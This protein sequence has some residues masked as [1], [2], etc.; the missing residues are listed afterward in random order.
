MTKLEILKNT[1]G[2]DSFRPGQETLIDC[3]LNGQDVLSV[4]PTGAGKSIC[5]QIPAL[6][7]PGLTLV[8]SPL[9]SLMKDQVMALRENGVPAAF[10]NSSM[11]P[12][13]IRE[14]IERA[15]HGGLK[16]LYLAPERLESGD[17]AAL[18]SA[19]NISFI[20]VDEAHCISEWGQDF[21]PSY[22]RISAFIEAL[23]QRPVVGAFTATAT[24]RVRKDIL[25]G[26]RLSS[27]YLHVAGFDRPNLYFSVEYPADKLSYTLSFVKEHAN[28]SGIIYCATRKAV[29]QV[30]LALA[31]EGIPVSR[32]HAGLG[33]LER[34]E[35]QEDFL[36]DRST[37]MAATNAFGMGIDKSNVRYVL[38]YHM[39]ASIEDYYQEAGRAG[40]DGEEA[41]CILLYSPADVETQRYLIRRHGDAG[42]LPDPY[43]DPSDFARV[44][45]GE[46]IRLEQMRNYCITGGCLRAYLLRYFGEDADESC[47]HCVNCCTEF[48]EQDITEQ[49]KQI[50]NCVYETRQRFGASVI[51]ET[52]AGRNT[53]KTRKAGMTGM[54]T[55]G[56]LSACSVKE[57]SE[58]TDTLLLEGYLQRTA[59][60]YP[61]L[62]L[63][64]KM[65]EL[66]RPETR[67][68][69]KKRVTK[70]IPR[71][72]GRGKAAEQLPLSPVQL[73]LFERL[74]ALRA[75]FARRE[76]VPPFVVF[77]DKTLHD[78]CAKLPESDR[79][80]LTVSG[81]GL[82]KSEKY[83]AAFTEE[84]RNFTAENG[85]KS[86]ILGGQAAEKEK[87]TPKTGT[88]R[89]E[90]VPFSLT[91]K[92]AE[93]FTPLPE[94]CTAADLAKAF[95]SLTAATEDSLPGETKDNTSADAVPMQR[96]YGTTITNR[97]LELKYLENRALEGARYPDLQ[98]TESGLAIGLIAENKTGIKGTVYTVIR[99]TEPAQR[100]ALKELTD[101][102]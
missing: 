63:T 58:M 85:G 92:Q 9:I 80:F 101:Q 97:F 10:V 45:E 16:L 12:Y 88:P 81:V 67:I 41:S 18:I 53:V 33:Q 75:G 11:D 26:L 4:M 87:R 54:K 98:P 60:R 59:D 78:M 86:A 89:Q 25:T 29:D 68:I 20:A 8:I 62:K 44:E 36:Y 95:M 1:Y 40:R 23:P 34:K 102:T 15:V 66:S 6:L 65:R 52:L 51:A 79:E 30:Y 38:H 56:R 70:E 90:K 35:S 39:P 32:Y 50:L 2:Y 77:S 74:R 99:F 3:I 96:L 21:R 82:Q 27:P 84:I 83:G 46:R 5:F 69:L 72:S 49:A 64:P 19:G 73:S 47:G 71:S 94:P 7:L 61:L 91:P 57:I 17:A 48:T 22:R 93:R 31:A 42:V 43:E 55:F 100:A 24:E 76:N 37:V 28:Q 13:E 14:T